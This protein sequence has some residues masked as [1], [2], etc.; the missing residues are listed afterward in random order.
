[1]LHEITLTRISHK[2]NLFVYNKD[3]FREIRM[4]RY[5]LD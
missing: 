2:S 3:L 5:G 1:M 4:V